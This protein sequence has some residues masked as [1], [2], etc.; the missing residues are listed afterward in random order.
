MPVY[1]AVGIT[2][3]KDTLP[4]EPSGQCQ[5]E[6]KTQLFCR[7]VSII[8]AV[9][10]SLVGVTTVLSCK[11]V[12]YDRHWPVSLY[13]WFGVQYFYYD[14]WAMY[15]SY[16]HTHAEDFVGKS[17]KQSVQY[18]ISRRPLM[19]FHHVGLPLLYFPVLVYFR[20]GI[21][22]FFVG[23][24][25]TSELA[26]PF[27]C[28]RVVFIQ[29]GM[30]DSKL[31][32]INGWVMII[33]F[34]TCRVLI[35]PFMYWKYALQYDIPVLHVPFRIPMKCNLSCLGLMILMLYWT[36]LMAVGAYKHLRKSKPRKIG[37]KEN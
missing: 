4:V 20:K 31:Y 26:V 7:C 11:D 30:K 5:L 2:C 18:F 14:T 13:P 1:Q 37:A 23:S 9:L 19:V 34:F 17:T 3:P 6:C 28:M 29:L 33:M 15:K 10:A 25:Y 8:Q 27:I 32:L 22:D 21:G 36:G 12:M 35:F 16:V 24:F